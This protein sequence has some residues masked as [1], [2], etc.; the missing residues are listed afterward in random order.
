MYGAA[1]DLT[2]IDFDLQQRS[3]RLFLNL[4]LT[5]VEH[6]TGIAAFRISESERGIRDLHPSEQKI[7][8]NFL[9]EKLAAELLA[10]E[11]EATT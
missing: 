6:A 5:D 2:K 3:I 11:G 10:E 7:V 4:R 8:T 1:M 9:K